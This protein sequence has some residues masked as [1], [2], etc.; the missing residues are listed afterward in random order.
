[1]GIFQIGR[2]GGPSELCYVIRPIELGGG[3][4]VLYDGFG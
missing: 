1:M 4:G 3:G 2:L